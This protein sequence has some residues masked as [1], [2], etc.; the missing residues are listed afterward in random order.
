MYARLTHV[1]SEG[2]KVTVTVMRGR[3]K[4]AKEVTLEAMK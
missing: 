3:E 1:Y 2:E 4:I